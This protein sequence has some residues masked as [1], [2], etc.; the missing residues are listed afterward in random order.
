MITGIRV[1][2]H[3]NKHENKNKNKGI[4]GAEK[5]KEKNEKQEKV[6]GFTS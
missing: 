5:K 2:V 3:N 6:K 1:E 4:L